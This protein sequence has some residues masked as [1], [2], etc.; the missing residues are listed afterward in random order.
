MLF[1]TQRTP[2]STCALEIKRNFSLLIQQPKYKTNC[3]NCRD[4][5]EFLKI[6]LNNTKTDTDKGCRDVIWCLF[7]K[8][9]YFSGKRKNLN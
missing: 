4:K 5:I 8:A 9:L 7:L 1:A 6:E 3:I 2:S